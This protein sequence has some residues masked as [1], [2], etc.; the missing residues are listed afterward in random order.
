MNTEQ[1]YGKGLTNVRGDELEVLGNGAPTGLV[2]RL[3]PHPVPEN[4]TKRITSKP[5]ENV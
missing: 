1:L 3:Q 4:C 2:L 5:H